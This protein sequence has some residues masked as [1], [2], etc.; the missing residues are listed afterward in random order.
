MLGLPYPGGPEI[1]KLANKER[2]ETESKDFERSGLP[3]RKPT[4]Q[5]IRGPEKSLLCVEMIK[6]PRPMIYSK[7]YDF[8][9]SGLKTA[10]LYLIRDIKKATKKETLD[11]KIIQEIA[12]DTE[13][14]IVEILTKKTFK[15]VQEYK[16]KTLLLGGGVSANKRLQEVFQNN[17]D[18]INAE[19]AKAEKINF[20]LP[21][22]DITMDNALMIAL[23]SF[24]TKKT[25]KNPRSLSSLKANGNLRLN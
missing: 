16:I 23:A 6:L 19:R 15:A 13:D 22:R 17:I 3:R 18:A 5:E 2:S 21:R 25:I 24:Y 20:Y 11:K 1:S 12:R 4:G 7:D 9:F 14:A 10:V 8:S